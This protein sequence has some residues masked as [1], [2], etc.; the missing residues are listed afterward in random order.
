M[1]GTADFL[2]VL[3]TAPCELIHRLL[4]GMTERGYGRILNVAS[5]AGLMPGAA[6]HTSTAARKRC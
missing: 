3:V 4:P 6:T 1:G 5:V 2:Q